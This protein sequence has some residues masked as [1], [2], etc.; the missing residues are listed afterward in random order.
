MDK[1]IIIAVKR[2]NLN[3]IVEYKTN[4][5][6]V[7]N[8]EIAKEIIS[9]GIIDN[10]IVEKEK[11]SLFYIKEKSNPNSKNPFENLEEF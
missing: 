10:A 6:N 5:N 8:Y 4:K 9:K 2:D 3:R 11:D 7:Y 1:E